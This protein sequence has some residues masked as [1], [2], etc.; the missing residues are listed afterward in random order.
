MDTK[1][2]KTNLTFT[3][4]LLVIWGIGMVLCFICICNTLESCVI[5]AVTDEPREVLLTFIEKNDLNYTVLDDA[6]NCWQVWEK[7]VYWNIPVGKPV[8]TVIRDR[9][10]QDSPYAGVVDAIL[11]EIRKEE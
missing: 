9:M 7:Q 2:V 3:N 11:V 10:L 8:R 5:S 4:V 6:G 1:T